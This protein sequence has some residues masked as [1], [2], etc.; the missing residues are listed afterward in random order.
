MA[1]GHRVAVLHRGRLEQV[2]APEELY[3][4]PAT[5]FVAGFVGEANLLPVAWDGASRSLE[6]P[7]GTWRLEGSQASAFNGTARGQLLV[8]PENLRLASPGGEHLR[9]IVLSST[10]LGGRRRVQVDA[11]GQT[12]KMDLP[13]GQSVTPGE[14]I[15]IAIDFSASHLLPEAEF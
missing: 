7:W 1:L 13:T 12:L 11:G 9:G 10:F 14:A 15:P 4:R 5:T 2:G 6:G 8:R 3:R